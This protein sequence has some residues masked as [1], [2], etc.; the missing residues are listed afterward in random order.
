MFE[1]LLSVFLQ[2]QCPFCQRTTPQT[3]CQ[4]CLEKIS[5]HRLGKAA[6]QSIDKKMPVFAWGKY[7]GQLK[8]AIA[9]MKYNNHPEIGIVLGQLLAKA[10]LENNL[11]DS[12]EIGV[13]PI[14]L[15]PQKQKERGFNQAEK[16]AKGF[17]QITGCCL[18]SQTLVR[19]KNTKAMFALNPKERVSNLRGAFN[20]GKKLP[21]HPILLLDDVYTTGM[22]VKESSKIL[23]QYE[24]KVIGSA[25]V[26]KTNL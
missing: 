8:R 16:I 21:S 15:H 23:S 14:P 22:T 18:H 2:S 7:D 3:I 6:R 1:Q 25:V 4:Y 5:S 12:Q 19:V 11:L 13:V 20:V 24:I 10:W 26:A 17:C 9:L